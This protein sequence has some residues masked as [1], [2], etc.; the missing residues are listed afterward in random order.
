[1]E[2]THLSGGG[3]PEKFKLDYKKTVFIGLAF[4]TIMMLW[5]VYNS[6]VSIFLKNLLEEKLQSDRVSYIV[7]IIMALDNAAALIMLP[8]FGKLSDKTKTPLGK[9]MPFIIGGT[10]F[11]AIC[12]VFI[13]IMYFKQSLV[14]M[15]VFIALVIG[16]MNIYRSPAVALM[17]DVT[18]KPLRSKANGVINLMGGIGGGLMMVI[19]MVLGTS[20]GGTFAM[21]FPFYLAAGLMVIG[22]VLLVLTVK[23][24]KLNREM[25]D[26][27]EKYQLDVPKEESEQKDDKLAY[28]REGNLSGHKKRNFILILLAVFLWFMAFNAIETFFSIYCKEV[29]CIGQLGNFA[30]LNE[31]D[32]FARG[33]ASTIMLCFQVAAM[34]MYI[35]AGYL[36][37]RLGRKAII[38]AGLL[39]TTVMFT[40]AVLF[41]AFSWA[42]LPFFIIAGFAYAAINV[43]SYP[44]VVEMSDSTNIGKYTGYYYT[45]SMLAQTL[46]PIAIGLLL[47][48]VGYRW[49][50][51]PYAAVFIALA[52]VVF[53][54]VGKS[55]KKPK[56]IK[57]G[58]EA[59]DND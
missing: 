10:F 19:M 26:L 3:A 36:A 37:S 43:N 46:T 9:R 56:D 24:N 29:L 17:P 47:D 39:L 5:Q 1:M 51:F 23:E 30:S 33:K 40:I 53:L 6:T 44:M 27:T 48:A 8:L 22:I 18:I 50:F 59:F 2:Q 13:P 38:L 58:L 55:N 54:F 16:F 11:A 14:G 35:P 45:A 21:S 57:K 28:L 41:N 32:S 49:A 42:L 12:F 31:Y 34:A 7:G 20:S 4:M 25:I 52:F 15:I